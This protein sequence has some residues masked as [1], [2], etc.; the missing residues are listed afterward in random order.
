MRISLEALSIRCEEQLDDGTMETA[1]AGA[2]GGGDEEEEEEEPAQDRAVLH[3]APHPPP[4]D[5]L[6][7]RLTRSELWL[8]H[9]HQPHEEDA[10]GASFRRLSDAA[11]VSPDPALPPGTLIVSGSF[12]P[13]HQGHEQM[14]LAA[15]RVARRWQQRSHPPPLIFEMSMENPDKPPLDPRTVLERVEQF[16]SPHHTTLWGGKEL[17]GI[18]G[19]PWPVLVTRAP[20]F[21]EKVRVQR[22]G[23]EESELAFAPPLGIPSWQALSF[24]GAWFVVGFDT[25]RRMVNP[26]YYNDDPTAVVAFLSELQAAGTRFLVAGRVESAR[27]EGPFLTLRDMMDEIPTCFR[28]EEYPE[29]PTEVAPEFQMQHLPVGYRPWSDVPLFL[30][31]PEE[32]FRQDLAATDIREL[33]AAQSPF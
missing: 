28:P 13:F 22:Q 24:P 26:K 9:A 18:S 12:N 27:A 19:T 11:R 33:A 17:T 10:A 6:T 21:R 5:R 8:P 1:A 25:A 3:V 20:L 29:P 4:L 7:R 15:Q 31:I 2:S 14:A 32:E 23:S 16:I 30:P